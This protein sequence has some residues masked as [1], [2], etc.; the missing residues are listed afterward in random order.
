MKSTAK[1]TFDANTINMLSD[2]PH[3]AER[4]NV[5]EIELLIG[6]GQK[7]FNSRGLNFKINRV[8]LDKQQIKALNTPDGLSII[9]K[10]ILADKE[11]KTRCFFFACFTSDDPEQDLD[12]LKFEHPEAHLFRKTK[13]QAEAIYLVEGWKDECTNLKNAMFET[14]V[15]DFRAFSTLKVVEGEYRI[16]KLEASM[17]IYKFASIFGADGKLRPKKFEPKKMELKT[18]DKS[19]MPDLLY[20]F[21]NIPHIGAL[22]TADY[23]FAKTLTFIGTLVAKSYKVSVDNSVGL[24]PVIWSACIGRP[25]TGKTPTQR[26]L[27][28]LFGAFQLS[29]SD[30][31]SSKADDELIKIA[32]RVINSDIGKEMKEELDTKEKINLDRYSRKKSKQG[33]I[34]SSNKTLDAAGK[35]LPV[36]DLTGAGLVELLKG[37]KFSILYVEDELEKGMMYLARTDQAVLR[38]ILLQSESGSAEIGKARADGFSQIKNA[39]VA[40]MANIQDDLFL[41]LVRALESQNDGFLNRLQLSV[42]NETKR[43]K[44]YDN[45]AV[46]IKD[47]M[48]E[49]LEFLSESVAQKDQATLVALDRKAQS[50]YD[51]FIEKLRIFIEKNVNNSVF[52]SQISKYSGTAPRVAL[53]YQFFLEFE[54][55]DTY[56]SEDFEVSQ[57]AF[58]MAEKTMHYA[59]SHAEKAFKA[60]TD[61]LHHDASFLLKKLLE[62]PANFEFT[63]SN[64]AQKNWQF[65]Q[66]DTQRVETLLDYLLSFGLVTCKYEARKTVWKV[67]NSA[68][69]AKH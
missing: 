1:L 22:E 27:L 54:K 36:T 67:R 59:K 66:R 8:A 6:I 49:F 9:G 11:S 45:D 7:P 50:K 30:I 19:M 3:Q 21:C 33:L 34:Q 28:D 29:Q 16:N 12:S 41:K 48:M 39:A 56:L 47:E 5:P 15:S 20:R 31:K 68:R 57:Q 44:T 58:L 25:G 10:S 60:E 55:D 35:I 40:L 64:I 38:G 65:I 2:L 63:A 4:A 42:Y 14:K 37:D 26:V 69:L 43:D 62:L 46:N 23:V 13:T 17:N 24:A 32:E 61:Q 52:V 51:R 18:L 53:I